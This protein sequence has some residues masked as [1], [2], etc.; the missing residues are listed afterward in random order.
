V[1]VGEPGAS[2]YSH[3]TPRMA[4]EADVPWTPSWRHDQ[5][6]TCPATSGGSGL[7]GAGCSPHSARSLE[8]S[9][10]PG[11]L[12]QPWIVGSK[13]KRLFLCPS[14]SPEPFLIGGHSYLFKIAEGRKAQQL[15]SEVI[16]Y[17]IAALVGLEVPPCFVA[18]D[19][20]TGQVGALIEF[21]YGYPDDDEPAQLV[22]AADLISANR[23]IQRMRTGP[24]TDRPHAIR[25]NLLICHAL[26]L[27]EVRWWACVLAF[28]ALIGNTDRHPE[29]WG[30]L[31]RTR[32]DGRSI[33]SFAPVFD[34][35][36][37]LGYELP[38]ERLREASQPARLERYI[39]RGRHHCGWDLS[40]DSETP[41]MELCKCLLNAHLEARAAMW[42]ITEFDGAR[43]AEIAE[44]CAQFDVGVPFTRDRAR[45][46]SALVEARKRR[47]STTIGE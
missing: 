40:S 17:R 26:E 22:H 19:H 43:V 45:F 9:G 1:V 44:E 36:T 28:D 46:V 35:G 10:C 18:V 3:H 14:D 6:V 12:P 39:A 30:F 11:R 2:F 41:H 34:N 32:Q 23:L 33:W 20:A 29:N 27:D 7:E 31:V 42:G 21:F 8:I 5:R 15:W 37:S 4:Q 47:L 38:E 13:P 16:A 25:L 24:R